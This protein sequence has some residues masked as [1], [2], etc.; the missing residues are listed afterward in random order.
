MQYN[1]GA[2]PQTC[3]TE[4]ISNENEDEEGKSEKFKPPASAANVSSGGKEKSVS[5]ESKVHPMTGDQILKEERKEFSRVVYVKQ[6]KITSNKG[7][8]IGGLSDQVK[9]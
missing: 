6:G 3:I 7:T 9:G 5:K 2:A 1:K 8:L 4:E